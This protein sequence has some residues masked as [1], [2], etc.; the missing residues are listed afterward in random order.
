MKISVLT[1]TCRDEHTS[2]QI[3]ALRNQTF[4]DFE[5]V[6]IDD[7]YKERATQVQWQIEDSFPFVHKAPKNITP[8]PSIASPFNDGLVYCHGK[9]VYFMNDYVLPKPECLGRHW[10]VYQKYPD[11]MISGRGLQ[12]TI[13]PR[14]LLTA[15]GEYPAA[16]YRTML[17]ET[18]FRKDKI[19]EYIYEAHRDGIQNWWAGRNDSAPL[20]AILECNGFDEVFDGRW[21]G[22]D[23]DLAQRLMTYGLRYI[24]DFH[25]DN[26]ALEFE[27]RH[28]IKQSTRSEGD[29]QA[30]QHTLIN[31]K[32]KDRVYIS[33]NKRNLRKERELCLK[34]LESA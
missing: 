33:D 16:D 11:A 9:L 23:A 28:G 20:E 6:L 17:F 8:Y 15:R 4:K 19:E 18:Y 25:P 32:V 3:E 13:H 31:R 2:F 22:Q 5:W 21:G 27:H 12:V 29:Q 1:A 30:F 26:I 7:L 10:E 34:P 24:L 14:D